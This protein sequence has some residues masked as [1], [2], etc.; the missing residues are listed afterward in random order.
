MSS[1]DG[2]G[3]PDWR[4]WLLIV[5]GIGFAIAAVAVPAM[6]QP[7]SYHAFADCRTFWAIPNF[8]TCSRT[9]RSSRPA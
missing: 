7:L 8:F 3:G 9:C 6:P 4:T 2:C 1:V 5:S